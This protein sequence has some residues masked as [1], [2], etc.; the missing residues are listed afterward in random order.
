MLSQNTDPVVIEIGNTV[1]CGEQVP[2]T[3]TYENFVARV[4]PVADLF[5]IGC[6]EFG[7]ESN[8]GGDTFVELTIFADDVVANPTTAA[9]LQIAVPIANGTTQQLFKV[10]LPPGVVVPAGGTF[11][12]QL[13]TPDRDPSAGGDGGGIYLGSNNN[14]QSAPSYV[15]AATCG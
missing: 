15:K 11:S 13:R 12:V 8:E 4:F 3:F 6:V 9:V 2:Q 5:A 7:V 1:A 14:G 10:D